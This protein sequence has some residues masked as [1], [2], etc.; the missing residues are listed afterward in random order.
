MIVGEE[1]Y[2]IIEIGQPLER[3]QVLSKSLSISMGHHGQHQ[4]E[5][6]EYLQIV[7]GYDLYDGTQCVHLITIFDKNIVPLVVQCVLEAILPLFCTHGWLSTFLASARSGR[8]YLVLSEN[9]VVFPS[10]VQR[11]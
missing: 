10:L 7:S 8:K 4:V 2:L 11:G 3:V 9:E 5:P 1:Q 6:W